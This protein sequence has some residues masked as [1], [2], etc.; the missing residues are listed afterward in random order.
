MT[1]ATVA[2]AALRRPLLTFLRHLLGMTLSMMAGMVVF[3]AVTGIAAA[4]AGSDLDAARTSQPELFVLGM[5]GSMSATMVVWMRRCGHGSRA[6]AEMT[7]AMFAPALLAIGAYRVGAISADAACPLACGLM[8]PA[9]AVAMLFRLDTY[10]HP[11]S[12]AA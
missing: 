1:T 9:M 8:V 11:T 10:T 6:A 5:A 7:A 3:G 4:A 2:R 12:R